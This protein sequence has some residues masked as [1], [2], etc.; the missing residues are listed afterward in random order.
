LLLVGPVTTKPNADGTLRRRPAPNAT[1]KL[2]EVGLIPIRPA[3]SAAIA[4]GSE[5]PG[6]DVLAYLPP[7]R[8]NGNAYD[9][10]GDIYSLGA[11]LYLLLA[12]RAPFTGGTREELTQKILTTDPPALLAIRPDVQPELA[13]VVMRMLAKRPEDRPQTAYDVC[14][15]V[16]RFG[17]PGTLPTTPPMPVAVSHAVPHAVPVVVQA[18]PHAVPV[19]ETP[20]EEP[21]P[22][23]WGVNA[24]ALAEAQAASVADR[25]QTRRRQLTSAEKS[26]SKVWIVVG[27]C[28]HLTA[29]AMLI[30]WLM[31]A[32][33]ST[34]EPVPQT[35]TKERKPSAPKKKPPP[36]KKVTNPDED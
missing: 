30:A 8:V 18:V 34:P 28:L 6:P 12:G 5:W 27:L 25:T 1:V 21:E 19:A 20:T 24:N 2:T 32:F 9:S 3:A 22:D 7:E 29:T 17:R 26:R 35:D 31:G 13:A 33:D 11:L 16:A 14:Q 23:A 4:S 10:R 15:A 36:R